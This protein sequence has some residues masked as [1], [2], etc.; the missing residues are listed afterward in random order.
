MKLWQTLYQQIVRVFGDGCEG[1][2]EENNT[3]GPAGI[4]WDFMWWRVVA[5]SGGGIVNGGG[6]GLCIWV[7]VIK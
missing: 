3:Y 1:S 7:Q 6:D 4:S 2:I 5:F